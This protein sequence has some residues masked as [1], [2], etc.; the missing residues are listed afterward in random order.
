MLLFDD[1]GLNT[2]FL[3]YTFKKDYQSRSTGQYYID[4]LV[5]DFEF[6]ACILYD[7]AC[8]LI[9]LRFLISL[10]G[11]CMNCLDT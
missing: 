7:I 1:W 4:S 10:V 5:L 3:W 9:F 8:T 11:K 6:S 2:M